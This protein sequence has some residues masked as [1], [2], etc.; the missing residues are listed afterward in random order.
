MKKLQS[1]L[2]FKCPRCLKGDFYKTNKFYNLKSL[3]ETKECCDHCG[4]KY[5]KETGFYYGAMYVSYGLGIGLLVSIFLTIFLLVPDFS[6]G[7]VIVSM[8]VGMLIAFPIIH[9]L[10]KIIWINMFESYDKEAA[11]K[12]KVFIKE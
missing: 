12:P 10:S 7:L 2:T 1:V 11:K 4:M 5:A 9:A 8:V 6:T 3:G